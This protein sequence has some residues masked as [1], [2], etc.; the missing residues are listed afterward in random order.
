MAPLVPLQRT[1]V[2]VV[3]V[4]NAAGCVIVADEVVIQPFAS[5][6]VIV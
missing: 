1:F 6:T 2:V 3:E 4:N 5:V